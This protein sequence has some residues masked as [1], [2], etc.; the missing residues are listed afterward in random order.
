MRGEILSFDA[1]TATGQISGDD[2]QRYAF[3]GT[4]VE[5]GVQLARAGAKV[6]F[7][8][9]NGAASSVHVMAGATGDKSKIVAALLAFFLGALGIHKFYIGKKN[10]GI[11][12]LVVFFLGFIALGIPSMIISLIA[13]IEAIIYLF[14]SDADFEAQYIQGNKAWF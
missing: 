7:V 2:G 6:D 3:N 9:G 1:A 4:D 5:N 12:M 11:I 10:A 13:F 8:E 14:K